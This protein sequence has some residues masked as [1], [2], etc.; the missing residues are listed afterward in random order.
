MT[1]RAGAH[2]VKSEPADARVAAQV[3]GGSVVAMALTAVGCAAAGVLGAVPA[4]IGIIAAAPV[5]AIGHLVV[6]ARRHRHVPL[7]VDEDAATLAALDSLQA[8]MAGKVPGPV[9]ARVQRVANTV[10]QT[11][12]RLD[13]LGAGSATAHT[14]VRTATSYLPEAV[15]AYLRLPRDFAD[16]RPVSNGKTSLTILCDQLDLLGAKMDDLF[17][18]ACR[19]DADAL[20][21]HGQF[22]AEKFGSGALALDP[23]RRA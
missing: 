7:P 21:A 11:I 9:D 12:P 5:Y 4:T 23:N 22:L 16:R 14:V 15:A 18:A 6:R 2:P 8:T 20:I 17:D 1:P 13:Q 19:A 3:A 10:R